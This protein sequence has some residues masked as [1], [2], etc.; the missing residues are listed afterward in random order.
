MEAAFR[1]AAV[2]FDLLVEVQPGSSTALFPAGF[3]AWRGRVKAR[4]VSRAQDG[5]A[6]EELLALVNAFFAPAGGTVELISGAKSRE[7]TLRVTGVG[8]ASAKRMV[9]EGL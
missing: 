9:R 1:K 5:A 6:N 3:D 7:K 8:L 4:V 2:G